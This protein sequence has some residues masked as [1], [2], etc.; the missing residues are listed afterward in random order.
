[1][2]N[3]FFILNNKYD[4]LPRLVIALVAVPNIS[5]PA[6]LPL[7]LLL[8]LLLILPYKRNTMDPKHID[9]R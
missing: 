4:L 3:M 1:M 9:Y 2:R 8:G 6:V 5:D 7:L